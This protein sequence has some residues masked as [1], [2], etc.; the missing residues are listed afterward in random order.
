[1]D[2]VRLHRLG[3]R[4]IDLARQV[5]TDAGDTELTPGEVAVLE[6]V[7]KHPGSAVTEI[8]A[9]TGFAQSHVSASVARLRER[10]L[11]TAAPDPA[12]RRRTRLTLAEIAYQAI[13]RRAGRPADETI[14]Q[15]VG[16]E[17]ATRVLRLLA[18]LDTLLP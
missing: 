6:D 1:M 3:K 2:G 14:A 5:T 11:I 9:R 18:E 17:K 15:V 13:M 4:L 16:K 7:L 8:Q 10:G 12:D